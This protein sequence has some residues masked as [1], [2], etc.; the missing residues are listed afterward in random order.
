MTG[1]AGG[2]LC[3]IWGYHRERCRRGSKARYTDAARPTRFETEVHAYGVISILGA[4]Q[5]Y[6]SMSETLTSGGDSHLFWGINYPD[7][8]NNVLRT[9]MIKALY[10]VSDLKAFTDNTKG[11]QK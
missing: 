9:N 10:T 4:T 11:G 7:A 5:G 1:R 2:R 8:L 3:C 6:S